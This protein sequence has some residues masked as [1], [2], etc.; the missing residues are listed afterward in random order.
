MQK[1]DKFQEEMDSI[2]IESKSEQLT[3]MKKKT[4]QALEAM[5]EMLT[6]GKFP[7]MNILPKSFIEKV[8]GLTV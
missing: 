3:E 7:R 2:S 6:H 4:A 5:E 8:A 1:S